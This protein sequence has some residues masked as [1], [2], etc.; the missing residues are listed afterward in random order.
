MTE[1]ERLTPL[2]MAKKR[3]AEPPK[4]PVCEECPKSERVG[5][6]LYCGE[7]G[8]IIMP[9]FENISVCRG[10]RLEVTNNDGE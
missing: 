3:A 4:P 6:L 1:N 2:E 5:T 10:K 9:R 7:S 8:K